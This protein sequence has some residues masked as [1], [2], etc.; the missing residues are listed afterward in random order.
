MVWRTRSNKF[1]LI[2]LLVV[3]AIIAILAAMLL[4]ALSKA[5]EKAYQANCMSSCKQLA[6]GFAM[7]ID[8]YDDQIPPYAD[9]NCSGRKH[10][11]HMLLDGEHVAPSTLN[12]CPVVDA[13]YGG[14]TAYGCLYYHVS[15]CGPSCERGK[16]FKR[17]ERVGVAMDCQAYPTVN[18]NRIGYPLTYCTIHWRPPTLSGNR[19]YNGVSPRHNGGSN[20]AFMDGHAK[21]MSAN[22]IMHTTA[23]GQEIWAHW[24]DR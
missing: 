9:H 14:I 2:E 18:Y 5:R 21:W 7:Y 20:V 22:E 17:P 19:T 11:Y 4:P 10:W 23:P 6:L 12:G 1:T 16:N 24:R 8:E 15:R 13:P 3:I